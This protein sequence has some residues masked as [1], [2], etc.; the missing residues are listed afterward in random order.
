MKKRWIIVAII[1]LTTIISILYNYIDGIKHRRNPEQELALQR[2]I[3]EN[4]IQEINDLLQWLDKAPY[5]K[6]EEYKSALRGPGD[7]NYLELEKKIRNDIEYS[8]GYGVD[9]GSLSE[10]Y[11]TVSLMYYKDNTY[12]ESSAL[13][14]VLKALYNE[15]LLVDKH[16]NPTTVNV[17][18]HIVSK[19]KTSFSFS[20]YTLK[21]N[22]KKELS[23]IQ[24]TL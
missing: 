6:R 10:E 20:I 22:L 24:S 2:E 4:R 19:D 23:E 14:T 3:K 7:E 11:T 12:S 8:G 16:G 18:V 5:S 15:G 13:D 21:E 1:F 9:I 17:Y